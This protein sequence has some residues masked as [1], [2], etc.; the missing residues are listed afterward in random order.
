MDK[1]GRAGFYIMDNLSIAVEE[2]LNDDYL[3]LDQVD[4]AEYFHTHPPNQKQRDQQRED[5][6]DKP[7]SYL[8]RSFVSHG[9]IVW[10]KEYLYY[11]SSELKNPKE[12]LK[13][14]FDI[15]KQGLIIEEMHQIIPLVSDGLVET[16]PSEE[17]I[18]MILILK[19][20][21]SKFLTLVWNLTKNMEILNLSSE[22]KPSYFQGYSSKLGYFILPNYY[23]NLDIAIKN[24]LFN[25][26]FGNHKAQ[27]HSMTQDDDFLVCNHKV[28]IK[29]KFVDILLLDQYLKAF[30]ESLSNPL[31]GS[32]SSKSLTST[33]S[34]MKFQINSNTVFHYFATDYSALV[35]ILDHFTN[36]DSEYLSA[37]MLPNKE[38]HTAL[39]LAIKDSNPKCTEALLLALL[40]FKEQ[41]LSHL[42]WRN[43]DKLHKMKIKAFYQYLNTC[44]FRTAQM[45]ETDSIQF[46]G[47]NYPM[48][49]A[50]NS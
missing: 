4:I 44:F 25:I 28:Y 19:S 21:D 50:H 10:D 29:E 5:F 15:E 27:G 18:K 3:M 6:F 12:P 1:Y 9:V 39:D 14:N 7:V 49:M 20:K 43:F 26:D 34:T 8:Q 36:S 30:T 33:L 11:F 16:L 31:F 46:E 35:E 41:K 2:P 23:V 45:E 42:I 13:I 24:H 37:I 32:S 48:I 40:E 47:K 22:T 38:G 17:D